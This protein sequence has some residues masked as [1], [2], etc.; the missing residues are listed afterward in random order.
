MTIS[1]AAA[2]CDDPLQ[3][4]CLRGIDSLG[5]HQGHGRCIGQA[6]RIHHLPPVLRQLKRGLAGP[7]PL[8]RGENRAI[9][10]CVA[11]GERWRPGAGN[12]F[13]CIAQWVE[14]A[15]D[16]R[17]VAGSSPAA[18]TKE[19]WPRGQMVPIRNRMRCHAA[20]VRVPRSPPPFVVVQEERAPHE[21]WPAWAEARHAACTDIFSSG[22]SSVGRAPALGA[23]CRRFETFRLDHCAGLAKLAAAPDLDS[24]VLVT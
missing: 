15:L 5:L 13:V 9:G 2:G 21:R 1:E 6:C 16:K 4:S 12:I 20:A 8:R 18:N 10:V 19:R 14:Q 22:R 3:G 11:T 23:G 17:Q 7:T 24:G